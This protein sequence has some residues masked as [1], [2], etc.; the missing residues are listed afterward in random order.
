[1]GERE[2][3]DLGTSHSGPEAEPGGGEEQP[4]ETPG[5]VPQ[6]EGEVGLS[7]DF[8]VPT[9][10]LCIFTVSVFHNIKM[11]KIHGLRGTTDL[12]SWSSFT[13]TK[14]CRIKLNL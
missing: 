14:T 7:L 1:M 6:E 5:G 4:Q 11:T 3:S 2:R 12:S 13:E 9:F 10:T 8:L